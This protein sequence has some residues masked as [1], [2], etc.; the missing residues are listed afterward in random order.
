MYTTSDP[1]NS[2]TRTIPTLSPIL[3]QCVCGGEGERRGEGEW[4][5]VCACVCGGGS[6]VVCGGREGNRELNV[7]RKVLKPE[8]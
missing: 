8:L 4:C 3:V 1:L 7:F 6:G 5:G 2:G